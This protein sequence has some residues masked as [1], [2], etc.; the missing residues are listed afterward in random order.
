MKKNIYSILV[1]A[2]LLVMSFGNSNA[3]SKLIHYWHF[4]NFTSAYHNPGIPALKADWSAL[5]TNTALLN[6][7]LVTGASSTYAGY[8]DFV[9]PGDTI[10]SRMSAVA[11]NGF[12]FRNPSDSAYMVLSIPTKYYKNIAV[13]YESQ[14]SSTTSGML[15]QIFAYSTDGG[16]TWKT[17]GLN[18]TTDSTT[19]AWKLESLNFGTDTTVNN[20]ANL[21]LKI[22]FAGNTSMTSGNNRFDNITVEGDSVTKAAT[23]GIAEQTVLTNTYSL[24]PNPSADQIMITSSSEADKTISIYNAAGQKVYTVATKNKNMPV[25]VATFASGLYYVNI[26]TAEEQ[27]TLHFVRK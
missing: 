11:G 6:Y 20:N 13:K 27:H 2:A 18:K 22:S 10:N 23:T 12:R 8:V 7:M 3:Q 14:T 24:Y 17:T 16:T 1:C 4:N 5:D 26:R 15:Q 19:T 9:T 25:N 21:K